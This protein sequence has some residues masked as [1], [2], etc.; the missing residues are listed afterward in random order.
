MC[1]RNIVPRTQRR[2]SPWLEHYKATAGHSPSDT[3]TK[4]L[5]LFERETESKKRRFAIDLGCGGGKDTF[6][7]L[8]RGW[9]V[10]AVDSEPEIIQWVNSTASPKY[11]ARLRTRVSF[12]NSSDCLNVTSLTQVIAYLSVRLTN[13]ILFGEKSWC[14]LL[15]AADSQVIYSVLG[16]NGRRT[17]TKRFTRSSR[18]ATCYPSSRWSI[19][20]KMSGK[21]LL[22]REG[23]N[24][25]M[26][27]QLWRG[28][29]N[30][31]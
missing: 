24:I 7:L 21:A 16:M 29:P 18:L 15:L 11:H 20:M 12:L 10:L 25:G 30:R 5:A 14:Q 27:S 13:L 26:C 31:C 28:K 8:R 1:K 2:T 3:L 19:S 17:P 4:A 23:G 6:E 22:H 9:K